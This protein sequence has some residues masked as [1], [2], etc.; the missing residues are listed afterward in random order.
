MCG[1]RTEPPVGRGSPS[2]KEEEVASDKIIAEKEK[3]NKNSA[4]VCPLC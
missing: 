2:K 4:I 1:V 3:T